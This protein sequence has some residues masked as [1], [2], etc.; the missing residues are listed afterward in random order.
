MEQFRKIEELKSKAS[1]SSKKKQI[2]DSSSSSS[3]EA[4]QGKVEKILTTVWEIIIAFTRAFAEVRQVPH[5]LPPIERQIHLQPQARLDEELSTFY[6]A[7][8]GVHNSMLS[9]VGGNQNILNISQ[10]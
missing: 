4:C 7:V 8:D 6:Q 5:N 9:V 10:F 1:Q 2:L 3:M